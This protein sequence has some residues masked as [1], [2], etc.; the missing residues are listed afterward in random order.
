MK[1]IAVLTLMMCA[2]GCFSEAAW[3]WPSSLP[4]KTKLSIKSL[5]NDPQYGFNGQKDEKQYGGGG[6]IEGE[7]QNYWKDIMEMANWMGEGLESMQ[8]LLANEVLYKKLQPGGIPEADYTPIKRFQKT[9]EQQREVNDVA[10]E[11]TYISDF[12]LES[13]SSEQEAKLSQAGSSSNRK[14]AASYCTDGGSASSKNETTFQCPNNK[15]LTPI[16]FAIS[17]YTDC[18]LCEP[19]STCLTECCHKHTEEIVT[20]HCFLGR[21][22]ILCEIYLPYQCKFS[23]LSPTTLPC[24][25]DPEIVTNP[26]YYQNNDC[27]KYSV[28]GGLMVVY[29]ISC[30]FDDPAINFTRY[31]RQNHYQRNQTNATLHVINF[32]R[33][34]DLSKSANVPLTP[35]RLLGQNISI[36]LN[37]SFIT[38]NLRFISGGRIYYEFRIPDSSGLP[39]LANK[40]IDKQFIDFYDLDLIFPPKQTALKS[41][42]GAVA[43]IVLGVIIATVAIV[44]IVWLVC[45]KKKKE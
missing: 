41:D 36:Y 34:T 20:C 10:S 17:N 8:R 16:D 14:R 40:P 13:E 33:L 7:G 22:G 21:N 2:I 30:E 24:T 32:S 5:M 3:S 31:I 42:P 4:S 38:E 43:A 45:K 6:D 44:V 28:K 18:S 35:A 1:L 12:D 15:T 19:N 29:Q 25:S 23:L 39:G 27:P 11:F 37:F 9:K 26:N